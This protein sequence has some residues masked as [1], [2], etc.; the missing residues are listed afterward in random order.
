MSRVHRHCRVQHVSLVIPLGGAPAERLHH[1]RRRSAVE[2][3]AVAMAEAVEA[4]MA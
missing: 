4:A 3:G 2:A 1:T